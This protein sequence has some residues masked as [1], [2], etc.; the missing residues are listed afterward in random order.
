MEVDKYIYAITL[1]LEPN[2]KEL[3]FKSGGLNICK[4][5]FEPE[6]LLSHKY[7]RI[8]SSNVITDKKLFK[9]KVINK[10]DIPRLLFNQISDII[11]DSNYI[12]SNSKL[13]ELVNNP[14][15]LCIKDDLLI[16]N[17][18]DL[19]IARELD[20]M[21]S[22]T[23]LNKYRVGIPYDKDYIVSFNGMNYIS[24]INNNNHIP[25]RSNFWKLWL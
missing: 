15:L 3:I 10:I 25:N 21:E 4:I 17:S 22:F 18:T 1:N 11:I 14:N 2:D 23:D 7:L 24:L 20:E 16:D 13:V 12:F 8:M 9:S 19:V 6:E 5:T